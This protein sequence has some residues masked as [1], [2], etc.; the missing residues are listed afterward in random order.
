MK[1]FDPKVDIVYLWVDSND[2]KKK[3]KGVSLLKLF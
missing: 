2:K 3:K 1:N